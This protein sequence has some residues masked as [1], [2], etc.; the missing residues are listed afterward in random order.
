MSQ[1]DRI[2]SSIDN[3]RD[4]VAEIGKHV[5]AQDARL[6]NQENWASSHRKEHRESQKENRTIAWRLVGKLLALIVFLSTTIGSLVW[7]WVVK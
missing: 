5:A 1:L 2:E 4:Y 6:T 7:V 3:I